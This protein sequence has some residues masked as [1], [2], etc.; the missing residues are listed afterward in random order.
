MELQENKTSENFLDNIN[1]SLK[2][3]YRRK[4]NMI[5]ILRLYILLG[6]LSAIF[7]ILYFI[8]SFYEFDM[9]IT[10][11]FSLIIT[12]V[13][14]FVA[15]FAKF[16]MELNKEREKELED[17]NN[18]LALLSSFILNWTNLERATSFYLHDNQI[19]NSKFNI[20]KN[21]RIL[22]EQGILNTRDF[23]TLE[24]ALDVRNKIV[25]QGQFSDK[26][27][28]HNLN[29]EVEKITNKIIDNPPPHYA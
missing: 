29:D 11:R 20:G 16:Y 5:I 9:N 24:K 18:D 8:S 12:G 13:G 27:M 3:S 26:I 10:Q 23:L 14:L 1:Y 21:L 4:N 28:I 17:K 6:L 15:L 25:H 2:K 7:G 22:N 19:Q